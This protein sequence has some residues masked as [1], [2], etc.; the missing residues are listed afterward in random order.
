[1]RSRRRSGRGRREPMFWSRACY[2]TG[3]SAIQGPTDGVDCDEDEIRFGVVLFDASA[4]QMNQAE[5]RVTMRKLM[6]PTAVHFFASGAT[7]PP[8][9]WWCVVIKTSDD[10]ASFSQNLVLSN[11][12]DGSKDVLDVRVWHVDNTF[13]GGTAMVFQGGLDAITPHPPFEISAQRKMEVDDKIIALFGFGLILGA[14][15]GGLLTGQTIS[16]QASG[17]VSV[18]WQRTLR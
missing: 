9:W 13:S 3:S 11:L 6:W 5:S 16:M 7:L 17:I 10:V 15:G 14:S 4:A 2:N 1:M 8:L 12:I 18:L